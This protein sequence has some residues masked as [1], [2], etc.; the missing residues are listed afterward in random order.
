MIL[1]SAPETVLLL[2]FK[3]SYLGKPELALAHKRDPDYGIAALF[4]DPVRVKGLQQTSKAKKVIEKVTKF[5][6]ESN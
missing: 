6:S 1:L 2:E 3:Q 5:L 4:L